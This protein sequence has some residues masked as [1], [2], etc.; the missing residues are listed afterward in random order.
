[1][2]LGMRRERGSPLP[3]RRHSTHLDA[4]SGVSLAVLAGHVD[5]VY[6]VTWDPTGQRIVTASDDLNSTALDVEAVLSGKRGAG[7]GIQLKGH[8]S[9]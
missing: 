1:M 4:E 9:G 6:Y 3:V 7:E 5:Y 8:G 2:S